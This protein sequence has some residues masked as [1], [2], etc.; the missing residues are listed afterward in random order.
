MRRLGV[1]IQIPDT[2][3]IP[4]LDLSTYLTNLLDNAVVAATVCENQPKLLTLRMELTGQRLRIY[5]RNSYEGEILF[6]DDGLPRSRSGEWHGYGMS[7]MR[8]VAEKY[9]GHLDLH[10]EN[11]FFV[12]ATELLLPDG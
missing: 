12:A 8:Q 5:C 10:C 7:L 1:L 3:P 11:G 6:R 4:D 9:G 2:L